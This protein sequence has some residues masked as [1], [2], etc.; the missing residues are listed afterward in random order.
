MSVIVTNA[1]NRISYNIVKSL[2]QK[3]IDVI[4]S[5]FVPIS[6]S[7][8]S[9]YSKGHFIYPSPFGNNDLLF[10]NSILENIHKYKA[11]VLIP[12]FEETFLIS[13][14]Y[15]HISKYV[16]TVVPSYDQILL[17]HNKDKWETV[18][19]KL[20]LC[21]P[22]T[23]NVNELRQNLSLINDLPFPILIKPKQGG[24]GWGISQ[25]NNLRE[26]KK[27]LSQEDYFDQPWDRFYLQRKI[28]G[29]THCVAMLFNKG[30]FRAKISYKQ[31]REFPVGN[32]QAT[33]RISIDSSRA[34]ND[35]QNFLEHVS[36]HGICQA[37]FI[38]EEST[39][40]PFLID[41]NPRFWGS[42]AQGIASGVD[43]PYLYYKIAVDGD[44]KPV[45]GFKTDV[46]T[47]WV[48]GDLRAFLPLFRK[49]P[50]KMRFVHDYLFPGR[51]KILY[52]DFSLQDPFPFFTWCFDA[53]LRVAKNRSFSPIAHDSLN[54][55]WE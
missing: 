48:G 5:D 22:E 1:K 10:I 11:N 35:F 29:D 54:G 39:G 25:A 53:L 33:L 34:E 19:K 26:I 36:W 18:A 23:F 2:G 52:D 42:L 55:V 7:F 45:T 40:I 16:S 6:M 14:Y 30:S 41:I 27:V 13:K 21:V 46:M 17:A 51:G 47:R 9:R 24:G 37:D 31:L 44:V 32:G 15:E 50:D 49:A 28:S 3:D 12:V 8:T 20:K 4:T 43:F 38:I